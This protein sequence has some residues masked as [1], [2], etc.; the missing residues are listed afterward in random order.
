MEQIIITVVAALVTVIGTL[1]GVIAILNKR[2]GSTS[3]SD[4]SSMEYQPVDIG[5]V[6]G[7]IN[8]NKESQLFHC[9]EQ[10]EKCTS[11][12]KQNAVNYTEIKTQLI[13]ISGDVNEI[14][15]IVMNGNG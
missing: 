3:N 8:E 10:L 2:L 4:K 11:E 1:G 6:Y 9:A 7:K 12:F 5:K 15:R 14:K 13:N